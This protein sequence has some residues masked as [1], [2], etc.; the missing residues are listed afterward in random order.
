[1]MIYLMIKVQWERMK[2]MKMTMMMIK[3][4]RS[5]EKILDKIKEERKRTTK[6]VDKEETS[7]KNANNNEK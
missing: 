4:R 1:M 2:K 3:I 5:P 7:S 6:R